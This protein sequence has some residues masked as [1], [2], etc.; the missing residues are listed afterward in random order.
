[1]TTFKEIWLSV[2]NMPENPIPRELVPHLKLDFYYGAGMLIQ[3][4]NQLGQSANKEG[5]LLAVIEKE[6]QDQV[7][8]GLYNSSAPVYQCWLQWKSSKRDCPTCVSARA[9]G[10]TAEHDV[11]HRS[12]FFSGFG[13]AFIELSNLVGTE[14]PTSDQREVQA[15][16]LASL[17]QEIHAFLSFSH[18]SPPNPPSF[19]RN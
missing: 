17:N 3:I 7:K 5:A 14:E 2:A 19:P 1:M 13:F 6:L 8:S 9:S 4:L 10:D 12:L 16:R 15:H 18:V 11:D